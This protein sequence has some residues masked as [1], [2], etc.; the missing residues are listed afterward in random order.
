MPVAVLAQDKD[1][2]LRMNQSVQ[3]SL[4]CVTE[5]SRLAMLAIATLR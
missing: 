1:K 3:D 5:N 2:T 4:F